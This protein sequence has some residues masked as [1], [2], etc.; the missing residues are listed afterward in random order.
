MRTR[1]PTTFGSAFSI[2]VDLLGLL[3]LL[4]GHRRRRT[5]PSF[6]KPRLGTR[7]KAGGRFRTLVD[8]PRRE[9]RGDFHQ[10]DSRYAAL[11]VRLDRDT[12]E[13]L[14]VV[15]R[16]DEAGSSECHLRLCEDF[17]E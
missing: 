16:L 13:V 7:D 4:Q 15:A 1:V 17:R 9:V 10:S 12:P 3:H 14:L 5:R 6:A 2:V 8:R 11:A